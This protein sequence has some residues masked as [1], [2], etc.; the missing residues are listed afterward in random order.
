LI[1]FSNFSFGVVE[2]EMQMKIAR[3]RKSQRSPNWA[4]IQADVP[5]PEEVGSREKLRHDSHL[6]DEVST[7]RKHSNQGETS[8]TIQ[9]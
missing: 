6:H 7:L 5:N 3:A 8:R 2:P 9:V 4:R 1:L